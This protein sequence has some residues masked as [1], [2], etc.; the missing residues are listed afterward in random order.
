MTNRSAGRRT[1]YLLI[2]LFF[3]PMAVAFYLYYGADWR[4]VGQTNNGELITPAR[5]LPPDAT[6]LRGKWS[7]VYIGNGRCDEACRNALIFARQTRLSLNQDMQRVNR[8]FLVTGDCCDRAYLDTVHL[9]L[10]VVDVPDA[11]SSPL[12]AAFPGGDLAT[13]LFVVDPFGN[14]VLRYDARQNPKGL[15]A[16]LRKLLKLSSIG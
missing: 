14:L 3:L 13:T 10:K 5:Q 1:L 16:D 12:L 7:L 15:L 8:I 11:A 9:G 4:P 6:A 2:A